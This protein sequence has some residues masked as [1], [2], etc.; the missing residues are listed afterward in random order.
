MKLLYMSLREEF[1]GVGMWLYRGRRVNTDRCGN[2]GGCGN[3]ERGCR[4]RKYR[5]G[6]HTEPAQVRQ[7]RRHGVVDAAVDEEERLVGL[8]VARQQVDEPGQVLA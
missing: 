1:A 8:G 4:R 3:T 7:P 6:G 2:T 5:G